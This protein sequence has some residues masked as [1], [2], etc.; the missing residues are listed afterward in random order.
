MIK[1]LLSL[2]IILFA[3]TSATYSQTGSIYGTIRSKS[4]GEPLFGA[5]IKIQEDS[6]VGI[7]DLEGKFTFNEIPVGIYHIVVSYV[8]YTSKSITAYVSVNKNTFLDFQMQEVVYLSDEAVVT[9]TGNLV[10]RKDVSPAISIVSRESLE[11][12]KESALLPLINEEVPGL[13]VTERGVT[14]FGVAGGA[15]GKISIRGLGGN[16]NTG[17]LVLIDGAPQY[18]GLFGHPLPDAY[19]SSDAEK[20]EVI[21]GPASMMY[22]SNAMAGVIN[23]I[24]RHQKS[25]G[26]EGR[27]RFS[28]GSF[29]TLKA[30]G[31][32]GYKKKGFE[33]FAS[34]NHDQ[35]DGHR[36]NSKFDI[37]NAFLK[38]SGELGQHL[39][40]TVDGRIAQYYVEDPGPA[41]NP[42][43]SYLTQIQWVEIMRNMFNISLDNNFGSMEGS[44][45]AFYNSGQHKIYDGFLSHDH[46][47]GVSI[48][49][50]LSPFN[51]NRISAGFD[52][53]RYGGKAENTEAMMGQGITFADTSMNELGGYLLMRQELSGKW[54]LSAGIRLNYQAASGNEW[55]PQFGINYMINQFQTIKL[56]ASKGFRYPTIRELYMWQPANPN[57][58][59][60]RMWCYES[61]ILGGFPKQKI[62]YELT[63]FFQ[64]GDNLIQTIGQYPNIQYENSG[65]FKHYGI[66]VAGGW[67]PFTFIHL[68]SNYSYLFMQD[69]IIGAPEHQWYTA[70]R[71]HKH[72]FAAKL[73]GMLI[74]NL[75]TN[76]TPESI[77]SY[78]MLNARI[79]YQAFDFLNVWMSGD[80]LLDA[81]YENNYDYPMPGVTF[82]IGVDFTFKSRKK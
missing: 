50:S 4:D 28:Y 80:N 24:S 38:L 79:S 10:A 62:E 65:A 54:I 30:M 41:T 73:S 15:A 47:Y 40:L 16:P 53:R 70:I 46:N 1:K 7:S 25:D 77:E 26:L 64:E 8:G 37:N 76:I 67:D 23:I 60:E 82:F 69:P 9:A 55:V 32:A 5:H 59:P 45:K 17:V 72:K 44:V 61:S 56:S 48:F 21:R 42:D 19:V 63:L 12:S 35:T 52:F 75:Y 43:S 71:F 6:L 14:G 57:L 20:V 13:F 68:E 18:M 33:V 39:K 2:C 49:E 27:A 22:G 29:N 34:I 78:Y 31:S 81:Q 58:D 51:G 36:E 3:L 74:H 66:E 11:E